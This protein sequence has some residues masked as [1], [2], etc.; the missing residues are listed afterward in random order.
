MFAS[1]HTLAPR[2]S[3][4]FELNGGTPTGPGQ[5]ISALRARIAQR[6]YPETVPVLASYWLKTVYSAGHNRAWWGEMNAGI[7]R[8]IQEVDGVSVDSLRSIQAWVRRSILVGQRTTKR[9]NLLEPP[10]RPDLSPEQVNSYV[11]RLLNEWLPG[12]VAQISMAEI[13]C[14]GRQDEAMSGLVVAQALERLLIRQRFSGKTLEQFLRPEFL[15]PLNVYPAHAEILR[16]VSLALLGR[17]SAPAPPVLPVIPF[18]I[19]AGSAAAKVFEEAVTR[20]FFAGRDE[21]E[22]VLPIQDARASHVPRSAAAP[23]LV[24]S[25][26][27]WWKAGDL[28]SGKDGAVVYQPRGLLRIDF[29]SEHARL[30]VPWPGTDSF[31]PGAV[32]LPDHVGIF[33]REWR[34]YAW[35]RT[36]ESAWLRLEFSRPLTATGSG[37]AEDPRPRAA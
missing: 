12:E 10:F 26:G 33:G 21:D 18:G 11:C 1:L 16:D 23:I 9:R 3:R 6:S 32:H 30:C 28:Q 24:T 34:C 36:A 19:A 13:E 35:E 4:I 2:L 27:R 22:L 8:L 29:S 20:A 7:E 17:T 15:S 31:W 25:D 37:G 5:D 14:D